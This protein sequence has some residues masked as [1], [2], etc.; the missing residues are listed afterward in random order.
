MK[1]YLLLTLIFMFI[2]SGCS[3]ETNNKPQDISQEIWD[4]GI[5]YTKFINYFVD[6]KQYYP[7][8]FVDLIVDF[9]NPEK[10]NNLSENDRKILQEII[11]LTEKSLDTIYLGI[12]PSEDY[13]QSL[14]ILEGYFGKTSIL[15]S[16]VTDEELENIILESL[17]MQEEVK[18]KSIEKFAKENNVYVLSKD[19]YL[20]AKDVQ[21][22][23]V[24]Y[25]DKNFF[26]TGTAELDDYYNYGFN[27][28]MERD[29]FV[30]YVIPDGESYSDGWYLYFHRES[31]NELFQK[32]KK[33]KVDIMATSVIPKFRYERGQN[34]MAVVQSVSW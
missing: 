25:L 15:S 20:T 5:K 23:M 18:S 11:T 22:D 27:H 14:I 16:K 9:C 32:L 19:V 4:N 7:D 30:A 17:L 26:I 12:E 2:L 29:Y 24:K 3:I 28:S 21:Y 10:Y 34:N 1:K 6:H 8:G 31:F 13:K 33:G